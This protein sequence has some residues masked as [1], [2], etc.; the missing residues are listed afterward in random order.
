MDDAVPEQAEQEASNYGS[1]AE[2]HVP[3]S[4][5]DRAFDE[6]EDNLA[7]INNVQ[8]APQIQVNETD[9]VT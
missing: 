4:S 9:N 8:P 5:P 7:T 2:H 1:D 3:I 6:D